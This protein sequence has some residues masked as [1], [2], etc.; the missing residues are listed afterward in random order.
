VGGAGAHGG[1]AGTGAGGADGGEG[2]AGDCLGSPNPCA[3]YV[4]DANGTT[5]RTSCSNQSHCSPGYHCDTTSSQC[6][7]K[8]ADGEPC[9]APVE[10]LSGFCPAGDDIC[11]DSACDGLCRACSASKTPSPDGVCAFVGANTDPDDECLLTA[12]CDGTGACQL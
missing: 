5:C 1:A 7:P 9:G 11:C 6:L 4:C 10:C 8:A 3:P 12:D 2:G